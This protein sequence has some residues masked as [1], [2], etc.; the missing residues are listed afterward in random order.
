MQGTLRTLRLPGLVLL[1][2]GVL[3]FRAYAQ[4]FVC[5]PIAAG[6]TASGLARRLTGSSDG[7]YGQAFQIRDPARRMFVPKSQYSR[8]QSGWQACVARGR[9]SK[10]PAAQAPSV[11]LANFPMPGTEPTNAAASPAIASGPSVLALAGLVLTDGPYALTFGAAL[12]LIL[13]SSVV[14][15]ALAP[16]PIPPDVR[17]A[18]ESF[19]TAFARPLVDATSAAPPIDARLRFHRRKQQLEISIAPGPGRRYPNLSDHKG[20]VEYDVERVMRDVGNY[21]LSNPPRA[22]GKWV[23]VTITRKSAESSR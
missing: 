5:W 16:R 18:G 6:D 2:L 12:L 8:I 17:L 21:V 13:L 11:E 14:G 15:G 23:V 10:A 9:V 19:V 7:A 3:P 20:N 4:Q 1:F 22:V